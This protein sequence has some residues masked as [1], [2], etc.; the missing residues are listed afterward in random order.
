MLSTCRFFRRPIQ[1]LIHFQFSLCDC[2]EAQRF[3][4]RDQLAPRRHGCFRE[5]D[6]P[7]SCRAVI[8]VVGQDIGF[9]HAAK[10][11]HVKLISQGW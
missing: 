9:I 6:R 7:A 1:G 5:S 2:L 10:V 3:V 11:Q 8:V 4:Q